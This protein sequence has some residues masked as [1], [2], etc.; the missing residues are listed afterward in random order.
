MM[1]RPLATTGDWR[2]SWSSPWRSLRLKL[3]APRADDRSERRENKCHLYKRLYIDFSRCS[4]RAGGGSSRLA[5]GRRPRQLSLAVRRLA[6]SWRRRRRRKT[7]VEW[8][9]SAGEKGK[10]R[11]EMRVCAQSSCQ[12][13]HLRA[14]EYPPPEQRNLRRQIDPRRGQPME[15]FER[16][17]NAPTLVCKLLLS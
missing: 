12:V 6:R 2:P 17:A 14:F 13:C 1:A 3:A 15:R 10:E 5:S 8:Q 9:R 16:H 7:P 4:V 11:K